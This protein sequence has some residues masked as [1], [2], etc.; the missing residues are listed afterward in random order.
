[1]YITTDYQ[2][3]LYSYLN[4]VKWTVDLRLKG[5]NDAEPREIEAPWGKSSSIVW[6]TYGRPVIL[7]LMNRS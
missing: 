4:I 2:S 5:M 6:S 1:M 3:I 7:S